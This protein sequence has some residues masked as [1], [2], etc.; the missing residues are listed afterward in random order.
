MAA[1]FVITA[2]LNEMTVNL[3]WGPTPAVDCTTAGAADIFWALN[4]S[5]GTEV[6]SD[7]AGTCTGIGDQLIFSDLTPGTY[8]LDAAEGVVVEQIVRPVKWAQSCKGLVA[9]ASAAYHELAP[10]KVLKGLMRRIDRNT[11]VIN[12]DEP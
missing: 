6:I 12:H 4:D 2:P 7:V 10:G 11:K 8:E 1:D 3:S 5:T 9:D